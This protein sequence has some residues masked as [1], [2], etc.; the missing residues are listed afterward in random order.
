M[1]N[2]RGRPPAFDEFDPKWISGQLTIGGYKMGAFAARM[3]PG[4]MAAG[5]ATPIGATANFSNPERR[6][7]IERHLRRVDPTL[8]GGRMRR[9][10]Q[11]AF[12]SYARYWIE[13]F[14]LPYLS[15]RAVS[16]PF[17][18]DGYRHILDALD[19]GS[20]AIIA[21]PHLGGWEWAGRWIADRGHPITVI[22]ER[23]DPP[24]LFD[25]FVDLRSKLGMTVVPLGP[26]AG[27][28]VVK[29]LKANHVVCLLSDRDIQG[30]GPEVEFFGERT[31]LPGGAATLALRTGAP[32]LPTGVYFTNR[33]DG[34]LGYVRPPVPAVRE[35]KRL[36]DDVQRVTQHLATELEVL[37]RRAPTQWHMFQPNWPSDP[38]YPQFSSTRGPDLPKT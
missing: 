33:L 16:A 32:I 27:T 34:H 18:E 2:G 25:W 6:A 35:A 36:R 28:A 38:G 13:S 1:S 9:A 30:N 14:R 21:L 23:L 26:E 8:R 3:L 31:T 7:M 24:E 12:D 22:V 29:A 19:V 15:K 17:V 11:E 4:I 5:L 10:V 37:I 20:G